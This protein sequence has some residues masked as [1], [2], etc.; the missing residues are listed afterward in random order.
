MVIQFLK[1]P[2]VSDCI[3]FELFL[4]VERV[5]V[6][7]AE[8]GMNKKGSDLLCIIILYTEA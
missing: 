1:N 3:C 6:S 4:C 2:R 7:V 5:L 8:Y